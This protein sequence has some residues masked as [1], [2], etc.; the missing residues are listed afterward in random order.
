MCFDLTH[1]FP[2]LQFIFLFP[3][4]L[5]LPVSYDLYIFLNI[6]QAHLLLTLLVMLGLKKFGLRIFF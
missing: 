2:F 3:S 1:L 5:F 4:L 6:Y